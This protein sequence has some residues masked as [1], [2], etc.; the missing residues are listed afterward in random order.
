MAEKGFWSRGKYGF[1]KLWGYADKLGAPVNKL[2][3]K[4]GSEA[5]WPTTLDKESEKA[6][7]I[8]RSFCSKHIHEAGTGPLLT[9]FVEDGFYQEE[10]QQS[11]DG[12]KVKQKILKKIPAEVI[13]NAKGLAI[14]TTMRTGLWISG[15]G[16][17]GVL[18]GRK[19]DGSWSPPAGILLHTAGLGFLVGVDIYDCVLVINTTQ[20]LATF[21]KWRCTLGGEMTAVAGPIGVGGVLDTDFQTRAPIFTYLKSRGFYAGVQI[22]GTVIIERTDENERFYLEKVSASDIL[23]GKVRHPPPELK[24]LTETLKAAQGVGDVDESY[25]PTE[26]PP[27]DFEVVESG[28]IF[29][30][31]DK[32]DPDPYGVLA[33]E[34]EGLHMKEAGSK[35]IVTADA[36]DFR[37]SASSPI[38]STYRKSLDNQSVRSGNNWRHSTISTNPDKNYVTMDMSTQTD[39][40]SPMPSPKLPLSESIASSPNLQAMASKGAGL[41]SIAAP[42]LQS[43]SVSSVDALN[44]LGIHTRSDST[45][46]KQRLNPTLFRQDILPLPRTDGEEFKSLQAKPNRNQSSQVGNLVDVPL[47]ATEAAPQIESAPSAAQAQ[48]MQ[49]ENTETVHASE[50]DRSDS[51]D[52]YEEGESE[53]AVIHDVQQVTAPQ[54]IT[55]ARVITMARPIAPV[56]PSRNPVRRR[57]NTGL[58]ENSDGRPSVEEVLDAQASGVDVSHP[59]SSEHDLSSHSLRSTPSQDDMHESMSSA[60]SSPKKSSSFRSVRSVPSIDSPEALGLPARGTKTESAMP[61]IQALSEENTPLGSG[62]LHQGQWRPK[63]ISTTAIAIPAVST[64][65]TSIGASKEDLTPVSISPTLQREIKSGPGLSLSSIRG[66]LLS[67]DEDEFA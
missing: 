50:T 17:S 28:H 57:A 3:N 45:Q 8:L 23:A 33:L 67:D 2:S 12:P 13:R 51:D 39:F 1:D 61:P 36:F 20:A 47:T 14:F 29:G 44:P 37:P 38:Y 5:F 35:M 16:G 60:S 42:A 52:E 48:S 32:E 27:A 10:V 49:L 4:L 46:T 63:S 40:P 53:E 43:R 56:I 6:A 26:P 30:V 9:Y 18:V 55:R 22:D 64:A 7:R 41:S 59:S 58:T 65:N 21:A 66:G 31:P 54:V 25:L 11:A 34:K 62:S 15:A 24:M 19:D